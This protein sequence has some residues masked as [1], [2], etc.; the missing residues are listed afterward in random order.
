[1]AEGSP[2]WLFSSSLRFAAPQEC[3]VSLFPLDAGGEGTVRLV[4]EGQGLAG[5]FEFKLGMVC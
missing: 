2:F 1:M 5:G 4:L 3:G